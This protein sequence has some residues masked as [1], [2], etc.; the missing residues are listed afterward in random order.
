MPSRALPA[1]RRIHGGFVTHWSGRS[2][3]PLE[4]YLLSDLEQCPTA[5]L[6]VLRV[7]MPSRALP[8]FRLP[9]AP[10]PRAPGIGPADPI[11]A[12]LWRACV[13]CRDGHVFCPDDAHSYRILTA[14]VIPNRPGS[15]PS[16]LDRAFRLRGTFWRLL[17]HSTPSARHLPHCTTCGRGTQQGL[18]QPRV[19]LT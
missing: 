12:P 18:L 16:A 2:Q 6:T 1:F 10:L 9:F 5:S 17:T 19:R 4:H 15:R 7:S 11:F 3:C 14:L 8:A 13:T